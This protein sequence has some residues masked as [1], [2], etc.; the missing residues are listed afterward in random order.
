MTIRDGYDLGSF[1]A[2][3]FTSDLPVTRP[4]SRLLNELS[5]CFQPLPSG[6]PNEEIAMACS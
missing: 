2:F 4:H 6:V 1:S 3:G 5:S